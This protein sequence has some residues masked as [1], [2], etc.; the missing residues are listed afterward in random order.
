[1]ADGDL[2]GLVGAYASDD[3]ASGSGASGEEGGQG[4]ILLNYGS[5][6]FVAPTT[7][8]QAGGAAPAEDID[9]DEDLPASIR[10][11]PPGPCDPK[12]QEKVRRYLAIQREQGRYLSAELKANREYRNP[13]FLQ[14]MVKQ[15]SFRLTQHV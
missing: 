8:D 3:E 13:D 12:L 11:P 7:T 1:M 9:V 2:L 15:T 14:K 5:G 10:E 4:G 6:P